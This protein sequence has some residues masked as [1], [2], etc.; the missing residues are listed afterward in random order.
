MDK[1][2]IIV[3]K[4]ELDKPV[5]N[6]R[7]RK[8]PIFVFGRSDFGEHISTLAVHHYYAQVPVLI[9]EVVFVRYDVRMAEFLEQSQFVFNIFFIAVGTIDK[10]KFLHDVVWHLLLFVF[11]QKHLSERAALLI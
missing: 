1:L 10:P 7:L 4:Y 6:L 9:D 2:Y 8:C 5:K 3:I 11:A